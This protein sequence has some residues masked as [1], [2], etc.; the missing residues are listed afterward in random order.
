LRGPAWYWYRNRS[1]RPLGRDWGRQQNDTQV[2][3][4]HRFLLAEVQ[5]LA[6]TNSLLSTS[7]GSPSIT[8]DPATSSAW[9][10]RGSDLLDDTAIVLRIAFSDSTMHRATAGSGSE[11]DRTVV[12]KGTTQAHRQP[13]TSK[14]GRLEYRLGRHFR[15]HELDRKK[16]RS[17]WPGSRQRR[18]RGHHAATDRRSDR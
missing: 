4:T 5:S 6:T 13:A 14:L 3:D 17:R 1:S 8:E 10:D 18:R 2:R 11:P 12:W 15:R 9:T 7:R 16:H